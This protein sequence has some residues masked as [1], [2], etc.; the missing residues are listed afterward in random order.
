VTGLLQRV[1]EALVRGAVVLG[2]APLPQG[3]K[4]RSDRGGAFR[5]QLAV[6]DE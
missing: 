6:A 3:V 2:A 1:V 5:G 4:H